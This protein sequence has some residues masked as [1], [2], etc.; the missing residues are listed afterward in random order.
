MYAVVFNKAG[1]FVQAAVSPIKYMK[2]LNALAQFSCM[3][4]QEVHLF[5]LFASY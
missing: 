4:V 3:F 1:R 5:Q 2:G